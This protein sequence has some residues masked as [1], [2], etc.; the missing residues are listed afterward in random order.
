M[1]AMKPTPDLVSDLRPVLVA[2]LSTGISQA[3]V[4][5]RLVLS[6]ASVC[7]AARES[8]KPWMPGWI[9]GERLLR[10]YREIV[11]LPVGA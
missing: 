1:C 10:L 4:A 7:E 6:R 5:R 2:I 9:T 3:E 8:T 11:E